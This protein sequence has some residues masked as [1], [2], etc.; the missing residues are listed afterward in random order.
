METADFFT[1]PQV[2]SVVYIVTTPNSFV[3]DMRNSFESYTAE[4]VIVLVLLAS[5]VIF[6]FTKP[7][8][9]FLIYVVVTFP[10]VD[11]TRSSFWS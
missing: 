4:K 10:S 3:V 1:T 5:L 7:V 9:V 6:V 8:L 11:S 2:A